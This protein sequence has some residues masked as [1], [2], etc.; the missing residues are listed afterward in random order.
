MKEWN[1]NPLKIVRNIQEKFKTEKVIVRSSAISEDSFDSSN[2][3][4]YESILDMES[5]KQNII[6]SITKVK[7][8]HDNNLANEVLVQ[9]MIE[10][11]CV[12]GVVF[13]KTLSE[14]APY[15]V[16]N[17]DDFSKETDS[18]TSGSSREH[19]TLVVLRKNISD[20]HPYPNKLE[21]FNS[22]KR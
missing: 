16:I 19:K 20:L 6:D 5:S 2:A 12:S 18:I 8:L 17:Y 3:G 9:P 1:I 10:D 22:R 4:A 21:R 13:T 15:Y 11:V 7:F 14:S